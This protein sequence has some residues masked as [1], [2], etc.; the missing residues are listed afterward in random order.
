[1]SGLFR[2]LNI[3][4][5][6]LSVSRMGV[7][8]AGHNISNAQVEGYS[9][10]RVNVKARPPHEKGGVL[11]G[12]GA[13]A[14]SIDRAHDQ[15]N[16]KQLNRANQS[17]GA[18][19]ARLTALK[20]IEGIFSPDLQSG[21]DVEMTNF[22]NAAQDLA[23]FPDDVTVRTSFREAA[24]SLAKSFQR[25]DTSLQR[26]R[27]DLNQKI[28]FEVSA[29]DDA[30]KQIAR[31]N[32]QIREHEVLPGSHA[33]DLRDERDRL[34]RDMSKKLD[35]SY[36]EDQHGMIC[37]RGPGD[38]MLVDGVLSTHLYV[39]PSKE[40]DGLF[41]VMIEGAEG[42]LDTNISSHVSNGE[43]AAMMDVRDKVITGLAGKNHHLATSVTNSINELHR[44]GFGLNGF[45]ETAGRDLFKVSGD[46]SRPAASLTLD[47]A[48]ETSVDAISF[49]STPMASGD[50]V[51]GNK[52]L[53]LKDEKVVDG[54][55]SFMQFY[56]DMVGGFG[57]EVVR[58]EH[59]HEAEDVMAKDLANRREAVSGVSLD[60][61]A[62]NLMRWQ[63]NF[64]ASSKLITTVD[65]MLDT[66]L[67]MKR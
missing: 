20:T 11:L 50:N 31:L 65:E 24:R 21:V 40:K 60:E 59:V 5:E 56:S 46:P 44:Q 63:A 8:T 10:Q 55:A 32:G 35:I 64:A 58:A 39:E 49:G 37:V 15:W 61:E 48:I 13:Y 51:I 52:I 30:M 34:L 3:G 67:S 4:S 7:D 27:L 62:T 26:E 9:R 33:N 47:D 45:Q 14:E 54:R 38:S 22:F 41:E 28:A 23:N 57:T 42:G 1:M 25:V 2:S 12:A 36:Y 43:I 18:A 17:A 66:V 6:S 53:A 19:A 16:E 29:V